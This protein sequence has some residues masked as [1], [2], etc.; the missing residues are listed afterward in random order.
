MDG[1]CRLLQLPQEVGAESRWSEKCTEAGTGFHLEPA[2][3]TCHTRI[4]LS[5][6]P[7]NRVW[8]S[9]DQAR[10]VHWGGSARADPA[11][12]G[13][14][15]STWFLLSRSHTLMEGPL[16]AHSQYLLGENTRELMMSW[17]SRV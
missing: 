6:Y 4:R 9:L 14:R 15:S 13:L 8:P 17:F 10:A 16:A 3:L 11:T 5:L 2:M 1:F 12:S 7:A